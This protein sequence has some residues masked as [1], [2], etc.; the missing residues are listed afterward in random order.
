MTWITPFDWR[1]SANCH[2]G[3]AAIFVRQGYLVTVHAC[4]QGA[5]AHGCD[6]GERRHHRRSC[7]QSHRTWRLPQPR[8]RS[9]F[10][11][12]WAFASGC[13]NALSDSSEIMSNAALVG[14]NTVKGPSL[15]SVSTKSAAFTA[16]TKRG[17]IRRI[18]RVL[19]DGPVREHVSAP[20]PSGCLSQSGLP[21]ERPRSKPWLRQ[22][23]WSKSSKSC[24]SP[25]A[26]PSFGGR[27]KTRATAPRR[28]KC[29]IT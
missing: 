12:S 4:L 9:G 20:R 8:D 24:L 29:R 19:D 6:R 22:V 23:L 10:C 1:T 5:A 18:H 15:D 3:N 17:V 25:V 13:N 11:A 2:S 26:P 7:P 27:K 21:P 16:A 28:F 14:A